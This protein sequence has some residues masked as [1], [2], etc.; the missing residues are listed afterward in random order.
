MSK[1][2]D[3]VLRDKLLEKLEQIIDPDEIH[4]LSILTNRPSLKVK[5]DQ[6]EGD[7]FE[8]YLGIMQ[9]D[10][11][12]AVLFIYYLA[13]CFNENNNLTQELHYPLETKDNFENTF[14]IDPA[15][16]DDTTFGGVNDEGKARLTKIEKNIPTQLAAYNLTSNDSKKESFQVPRPPA[17]EPP[18]PSFETL[19]AHKDDKPQWSDL[20]F[21]VNYKPPPI[22]NPHPDWKKCKL[23]AE[24]IQ[25]RKISPSNIIPNC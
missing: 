10:C 6:Y 16:A 11:L 20:D 15:Y 2:F 9:G 4:L 25:R 17:P 12:S 14:H 19:L 18:T 22:N 23:L 5:I 24:D 13:E 3:T 1:A 8:T 7:K 21:L